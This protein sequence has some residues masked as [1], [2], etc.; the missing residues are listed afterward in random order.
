MARLVMKFGGVSVADGQKLRHVGDLVRQ[1]NRDNE[2]V[3]VTSA[4]QGV[5]DSL[6]ECARKS[7]NEGKVSDVQDFIKKLTE[8]HNQAISEAITDPKIAQEVRE[9]VAVKISELEKAYI[10]ICYLGEL[11]TRS[12][13]YI[14]SYGE[15][16]AAPI[17]SGVLRDMGI[18]SRHFTGAEA[19]IITDS[20]YGD[21][22]P[23]GK[24]YELI[25]QRLLPLKGVPVVTGF[26]AKDEKGTITTLGRGGSDLSASLIGAAIDADEI[27][28]WKETPGVL[29]TDPKI[30]P[31]AKTIPSISYREAME[32]SYFGAKVL[33]PRAIEP[34]IKKGIPVRVKNTFDPEGP[35]TQ[36]VQNGIKKKGVIKAVTVSKKVALLNISGAEMIGTPGVAAQVFTALAKAGV[37]IIMISQG[38]SEA[39]ISIVIEER[40]VD[41]AE[42]A[43][44]A[45][46]SK[47]LVKDISHN[48]N[49][50]ALAVVGAGMAGTPGVAARV[51]KAMGGAGINVVMISQGSSEHNISFVV[52]EKDAEKA[53]L[54]LHR[55][56]G[57]AEDSA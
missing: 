7:A 21:S 45:E 4:L 1:F 27:W 55:E 14:S 57:L 40:H 15:Q 26:I 47:D 8:R 22:H 19:G 13:D 39:N 25:P 29:T 2:I 38:S 5:T 37:N 54:E 48:H 31:D 10:G 23:L 30:V 42:A 43:L 51:F 24:T 16:L 33:H 17:L 36:I 9:V 44:R 28:F 56:F 12:L 35:G 3:L 50:S 52:S 6:L 49:V 11:T 53:V 34:A 20:E 46:L 41:K 18:P 32:L